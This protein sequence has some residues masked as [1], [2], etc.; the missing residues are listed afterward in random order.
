MKTIKQHNAPAFCR[1]LETLSKLA[2]LDYP[3][4]F[5][6]FAELSKIERKVNRLTTMECNGE[7]NPEQIEKQLNKLEIKV[8]LLLPNAKTLFLNGDPRGY[9]LKIKESEARELGIWTD[10]GGYGIIVPQF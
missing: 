10:F 8:K 1:H 9:S 3:Y 6:L 5:D 7:G 2:N 4:P